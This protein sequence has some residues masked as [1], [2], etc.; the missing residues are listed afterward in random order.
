MCL[1]NIK[2]KNK[3]NHFKS[4]SHIEFDNGKHKILS[5][6]DIIINDVDEAF[7]LYIIEHNKKF[8]S[9]LIKYQFKLVLIDYEN[10][11][12]VTSKLSDNKTLIPWKSWLEE[13]I[14]D[15]ENK[16]YIFKHIAEMHIITI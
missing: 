5:H 11:S 9:Y 1:K 13:I 15:F 14:E 16:A 8:D 12:Y 7:Y 3:N 2:T 4:K 10:C 6:K